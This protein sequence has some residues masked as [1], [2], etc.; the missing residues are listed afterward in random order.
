LSSL[1]LRVSRQLSAPRFFWAELFAITLIT[2]ALFVS[3]LNSVPFH[4]DES[5]WIAFSDHY[6]DYLKGDF[7]QTSWPMDYW[8]ATMPTMPF[9]FIGVGRQLGG[10]GVSDLNS[11]WNWGESPE[12]NKAKG[13]MPSPGLLWWSRLPMAV[14]GILGTPI[15]FLFTAK[16]GGRLAGYIVVILHIT[17]SYILTTLSRAMSESSL[18]FWTLIALVSCAFS[19]REWQKADRVE[20]TSAKTHWRALVGLVVVG[21]AAGLA[22]ESKLNGLTFV[23]VGVSVVGLI[24]IVL[25][26]QWKSKSRWV[27][28]S[29]AVGGLLLATGLTFL[30]VDPVFF[31]SPWRRI[32]DVF[33]ERVQVFV[34][35]ATMDPASVVNGDFGR[36]LYRVFGTYAALPLG[37]FWILSLFLALIG[38][39]YVARQSWRLVQTERRLDT[40]ALLLLAALFVAGPALLTP[41]DWDRYFILPV[42]FA[43]IFIGIALGLLITSAIHWLRKRLLPVTL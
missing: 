37:Q 12:V 13:Q 10:Y 31:H 28:T 40:N 30:L 7:S 24:V 32:P 22:G 35:A 2:G 6:E 25:P 41:I 16:L 17:N 4:G 14:L 3:N 20:P 34:D 39:L 23:A 18:V 1:I 9:Y 36:V 5:T 27:L 29:I 19:V 43:T 8:A 21:I 38:L 11:N 26:N 33:I 15:L 42:I